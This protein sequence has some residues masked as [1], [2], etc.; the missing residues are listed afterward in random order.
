MQSYTAI[1]NARAA[2]SHYERRSDRAINWDVPSTEDYWLSAR[3]GREKAFLPGL[4]CYVGR[5]VHTPNGP[6]L[7]VQSLHDRAR[8]LLESELDRCAIFH[9]TEVEPVSWEL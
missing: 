8:V 3:P 4:F 2:E 9:L 7:L 6:G 1:L 5:K